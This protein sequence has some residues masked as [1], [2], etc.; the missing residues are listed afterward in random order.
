MSKY[1]SRKVEKDGEVFDSVKEYR[2]YCELSLMERAGAITDLER[3]VKYVLL[4]A[5]YAPVFDAKTKKWKDK[6]IERECSYY[7]DFVYKENGKRIVEDTKGFRT[8]EYKIKRKLMYYIH[9]I[10]IKEV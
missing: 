2:R 7:A 1:H 3:Q 10:Q 9:G 6:C 8:P 4:P 5:Q